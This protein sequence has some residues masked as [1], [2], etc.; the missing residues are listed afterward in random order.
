M[1][2]RRTGHMMSVLVVVGLG[3]AAWHAGDCVYGQAAGE[4]KFSKRCLLVSPNEGCAV[5]DVDRDGKP[6][7]VAGTHWF[8]G[9]DFVPRPVRDVSTATAGST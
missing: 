8:Q 2:W 4:V 5:G 6:D 7:V 9:P 3:L 1:L